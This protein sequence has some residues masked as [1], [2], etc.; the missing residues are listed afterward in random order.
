MATTIEANAERG[1]EF[2][3]WRAPEQLLL[4]L[5]SLSK[6]PNKKQV[7]PLRKRRRAEKFAPGCPL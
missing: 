1:D 4:P 2:K 3:L 7:H 6:T 5:R